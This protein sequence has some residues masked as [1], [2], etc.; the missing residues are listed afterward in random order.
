MQTATI[1]KA[2]FKFR[3][4][5]YIQNLW[6]S[7]IRDSSFLQTPHQ[8]PPGK[9]ESPPPVRLGTSTTALICTFSSVL[10]GKSKEFNNEHMELQVQRALSP[11]R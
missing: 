11:K 1:S 2:I 6:H 9:Q 3:S 8:V 4:K 5:F 7:F 10:K